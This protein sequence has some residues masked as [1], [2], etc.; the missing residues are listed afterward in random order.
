MIDQIMNQVQVKKTQIEQLHRAEYEASPDVVVSA[1]GMIRLLGEHTVDGGGVM[2]SFPM[3]RRVSV[4]VSHRRDSSVRFYAADLNERKRTNL[5]NLKYKREDRWANLI[6]ASIAEVVGESAATKGFNVTVSG[7]VPQGL[8]LGSATALRCAAAKA[9]NLIRGVSQ[10]DEDAAR[11][12]A[13]SDASFFERP[14]RPAWYLATLAAKEDSMSVVDARK[15]SVEI[16]PAGFGGRDLI[17][18]DSRV[19]RPPQDGELAQRAADCATGL[20]IMGGS[21]QASLRDFGLDELDEY[22][23]L[24]PERVRRHCA[25]FVEEVQRAR[26]ARDALAHLD[27][28][29]FAKAV[30]KSQAGLRNS[31]EIS[32]PEIDWLVKRA[33][34]IDGVLAARMI[35]RGFG[36]CTLVAVRSAAAAEYVSRLD[37]YERIFGFKPS[38]LEIRVGAGMMDE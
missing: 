13:R 23:G 8:G 9:V 5:S 20:S 18:T 19:P 21:G 16:L 12:I 28:A 4:A 15:E 29:G 3:D 33:M 31:Y 27:E 35:G 36:G 24:M 14:T 1:P 10:G 34:E 2:V 22:M 37:E 38:V 25:F 7:D 26:E 32:C 17:L 30:N 6:K 11:A